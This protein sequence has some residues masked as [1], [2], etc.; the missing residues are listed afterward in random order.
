MLA[1]SLSENKLY[2]GYNLTAVR[3]G[4]WK[5]IYPHTFS[6]PVPPGKNGN[7]GKRSRTQFKELSLFDLQS[8]PGETA[9]VAE[10][11]PEAVKRLEALA[12]KARGDLGDRRTQ[13]KGKNLR[14]VGRP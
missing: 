12:E 3:S 13:R 1:I 7:P 4:K 11:N 14:P 5:L 2:L 8:D 9:N 10:K 6:R